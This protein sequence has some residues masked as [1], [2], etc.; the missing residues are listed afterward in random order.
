M[1]HNIILKALSSQP[2]PRYVCWVCASALET[3]RGDSGSQCKA[4]EW[5]DAWRDRSKIDQRDWAGGRG[6]TAEGREGGCYPV[7]CLREC[8]WTPEIH[9][10][11]AAEA[12]LLLPDLIKNT[13]LWFLLFLLSLSHSTP[14]KFH[15]KS[16]GLA[17]HES[18]SYRGAKEK[19]LI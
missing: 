4:E 6:R 13:L 16:A 14:P 18:V 7:V 8:V 3:K 11:P 5:M 1:Y 12:S 15:F 17:R 19:K 10:S 2:S 9:L